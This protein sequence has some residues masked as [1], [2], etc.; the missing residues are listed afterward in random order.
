MR[1]LLTSA[2]L[3][4]KRESN[5]LIANGNSMAIHLKFQLLLKSHFASPKKRP[6]NLFLD[7][8]SILYPLKTPEKF[9]Y[10]YSNDLFKLNLF[11]LFASFGPGHT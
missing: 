11:N 7:K 4:A 1:Y 10:A 8:F 5:F 3:K 2:S 9:Y 6:C